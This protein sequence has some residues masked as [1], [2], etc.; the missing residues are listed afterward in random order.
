M[1]L[2]FD[3]IERAAAMVDRPTT[4]EF[5]HGDRPGLADF[6]LVPQLYNAHRWGADIGGL[7][8]IRRIGEACAALP[9]F[10]AAHPDTVNAQT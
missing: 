2:P 7:K 1:D 4:G 10:R 6:C 8:T 3:P 9:A 5:C